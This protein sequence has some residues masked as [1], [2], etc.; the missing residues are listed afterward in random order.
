MLLRSKGSVFKG[1]TPAE[2][3]MLEAKVAELG[4]C[5]G[6]ISSFLPGRTAVAAMNH[7]SKLH[8]RSGRKASSAFEQPQQVASARSA[9]VCTVLETYTVHW[10]QGLKG[11]CQ[12]IAYCQLFILTA[13]RE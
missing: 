2:N 8:G 13:P 10:T 4:H 12:L 11:V 6:P 1:W 3:Q 9:G 7:W 5:W